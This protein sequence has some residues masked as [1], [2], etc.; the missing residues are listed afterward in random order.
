M[1]KIIRWLTRF[2]ANYFLISTGAATALFIKKHFLDF[3][4][5]GHT[6]VFILVLCVLITIEF[7][8]KK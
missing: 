5:H 8:V 6:Y 7:K 1:E 2:C 4:L 3:Y